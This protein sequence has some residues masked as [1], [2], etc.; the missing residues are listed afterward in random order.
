MRCGYRAQP[1]RRDI[2][3]R[4]RWSA[5]PGRSAAAAGCPATRR[6]GTGSSGI[7]PGRSSASHC[8]HTATRSSSAGPGLPRTAISATSRPTPYPRP[9]HSGVAWPCA[10]ST[11]HA[12]RARPAWRPG[13]WRHRHRACPS[14]RHR[15]QTDRRRRAPSS[16]R[17]RHARWRAHGILRCGSGSGIRAAACAET[18]SPHRRATA[19]CWL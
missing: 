5:R 15:G 14:H 13:A 6:P 19:G 7:Q 3:P 17:T 12:G 1:R 16:N 2:R 8:A 9:A 10:T 4:R 18:R 11:P